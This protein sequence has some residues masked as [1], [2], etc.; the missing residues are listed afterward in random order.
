MALIAGITPD[1]QEKK[2]E[3]KKRE[4]DNFKSQTLNPGNLGH[5]RVS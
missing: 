4:K 1:P 3:N 2:K 5:E